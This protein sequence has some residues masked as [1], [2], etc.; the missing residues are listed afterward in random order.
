MLKFKSHNDT[1]EMRTEFGRVFFNS[2]FH[3]KNGEMTLNYN[4]EWV[5]TMNPQT[6][7]KFLEWLGE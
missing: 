5:G 3:E 7:T 6:A 2:W 1:V 4:N